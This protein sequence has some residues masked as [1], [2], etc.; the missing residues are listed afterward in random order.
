MGKKLHDET[1]LHLNLTFWEFS[2]EIKTL[3]FIWVQLL[4]YLYDV[5][6]IHLPNTDIS[7]WWLKAKN[8]DCQFNGSEWH[9]TCSH[10]V[11]LNCWYLYSGPGV[12]GWASRCWLCCVILP[13]M[14]IRVREELFTSP[15]TIV[16]IPKNLSLENCVRLGFIWEIETGWALYVLLKQICLILQ[17]DED[18]KCKD[19]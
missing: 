3:S 6:C 13:I 5:I 1:L 19:H 7:L 16:C 15:P 12:M 11:N 8:S 17:N 2:Y 9:T 4:Q 10:V 14:I 18:L